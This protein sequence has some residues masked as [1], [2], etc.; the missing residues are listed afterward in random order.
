MGYLVCVR[1]F[2]PKPLV[3]LFFSLTYSGVVFFFQHYTPCKIFFLSV[4][5]FFRQVFPCKKFFPLEIRLHCRIIFFWNH[6]RIPPSKV[7]GS[8]LYYRPNS[9]EIQVT[10]LKITDFPHSQHL[11]KEQAREYSKPKQTRCIPLKF[12]NDAISKFKIPWT[13]PYSAITTE[14]YTVRRYSWKSLEICPALFP[15]LEK[16]WNLYSTFIQDA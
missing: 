2:F 15:D 6:L 5:F 14:G 3:I 16:V 13:V 7:K 11:D 8:A 12:G 1:I 4:G 10:V 9:T